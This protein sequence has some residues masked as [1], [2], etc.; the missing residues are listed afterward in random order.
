M[1]RRAFLRFSSVLLF[2]LLTAC[3]L[4]IPVSETPPSRTIT[5]APSA[6]SIPYTATPRPTRPPAT[7]T[8]PPQPTPTTAVELEVITP[9]NAARLTV[10]MQF[11]TGSTLDFAWLP[12]NQ[13]LVLNT[14]EQV[15]TTSGQEFAP[16]AFLEAS[17]ITQFLLAPNGDRYAAIQSNTQVT[18]GEL[19]RG[20][21]QTLAAL[22]GSVTSLAFSPDSTRLAVASSD[23][24]QVVVWDTRGGVILANYTLP[25]W[26]ED[27]AI[28]ADNTLLAG[29]DITQFSLHF[30]DPATGAVLRSLQWTESASPA[31]Y[32]AVLS[33][34]WSQIAWFARGTLQLMDAGSGALGPALDH[35]D[36]ISTI[37]WSP[38]S[39]IVASAA[40]AT[41]A[42][43]FLPVVILWDALSGEQLAVLAL[44]NPV[45]QLKFNPTGTQLGILTSDGGFQSW[46]VQP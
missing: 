3:D 8:Q 18:L 40:A 43:Q 11:E 10:S 37:A 6:T 2:S 9:E 46:I 14:A 26:L 22:P 29:V 27:L 32:G 4:L 41:V 23:A 17:S 12:Q 33:P 30:L 31:L 45:T 44:K 15:L 35:E 39:R 36:F 20:I 13:G 28:S 34:D 25:Y 19:G 16:S 1:S 7:V 21:T 5:Q 42:E 38:D 24:N